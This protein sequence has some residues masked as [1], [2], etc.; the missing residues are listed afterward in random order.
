MFAPAFLVYRLLPVPV[1]VA[2]TIR[3]L[4][5][6]LFSAVVAPSGRAPVATATIAVVGS[7]RPTVRR[8]GSRRPTVRRVGSRQHVGRIGPARPSGVPSLLRRPLRP[9]LVA[10]PPLL[11]ATSLTI[12]LPPIGRATSHTASSRSR[13][14][15][16]RFL[17]LRL[18]ITIFVI[19][20]FL[21]SRFNRLGSSLSHAYES[22]RRPTSSLTTSSLDRHLSCFCLC[23]EFLLGGAPFMLAAGRARHCLMSSSVMA[24]RKRDVLP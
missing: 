12:L 4:R 6:L 3:L 15:S 1:S 11:L 18:F 9:A 7:R 14:G 20:R 22:C 10:V 2:R 19:G 13:A 8:V 24:C 17:H 23:E 5:R 16:R 21:P